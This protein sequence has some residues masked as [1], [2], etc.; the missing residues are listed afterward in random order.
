MPRVGG[1]MAYPEKGASHR[2]DPKFLDRMKAEEGKR[3][4]PFRAEG[5][6]VEDEPLVQG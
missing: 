1:D 4:T 3:S 6:G 2:Y 5:G